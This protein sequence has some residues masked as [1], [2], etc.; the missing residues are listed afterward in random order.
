MANPMERNPFIDQG[1]GGNNPLLGELPIN[2]EEIEIE[3][4]VGEDELLEY[5]MGTEEQPYNHW[6]NLALS[7]DEDE[8]LEIANN[9]IEE[10][11]ADKESR[12]EWESTFERGFDLLGLKL[13]ETSEPFEGACTAVHPLII[14]SAV[15]FQAKASQELF[16]AKGP[17]RTQIL[18]AS[19]PEKEKQANRVMNFMNYQ[20][21]QQMPEYFDETERMLFNLPVFGSAFKKTYYDLT[22]ER[23]VVE[24]VPIDNF[25]VS[26]NASDLKNADHYTQVIYR[27]PND[28]KKDIMAGMYALPEDD[29]LME[30][31][32][33]TP[34]TLRQKMDSI[35]GIQ[36]DYSQ[37][38]QH[39]LL[40]HHCYLKIEH[41]GEEGCPCPM[42]GE[43]E[44]DNCLCVGLPYVITVDQDSKSVL[45]IRRNWN[46]NDPL[47]EKLLWFTHYRFVP[48]FG[49]YGLGY[50]H[51]LGNLTATSTA[52]MRNLI[53]AGQFATL[54]GGFKARG[55]RVTGGDEPIAPGEFREVEATGVDLN[56]AIINLPYKEP[57]ATL[58]QM[59][60]FVTTA[61]QKFADETDQVVSDASNYGPVGTTVAL[62]EQSMKFF[63]GI[64]KRLHYSQRQELQILSR[65][66]YDFLP[67]EYPYDIPLVDGNIFKQD[68]DGRIDIIPVSDPNIPSQSHRLAKAQM[69]LQ[70]SSQ[71]PPGIYNF[72]A[73]NAAILDS[74]NIDHPERFIVPEQEP[75]PL[76]P[77]SDIMQATK[78]MPIKAFPGQDHKAHIVVKQSFIQD[79]TLG[80]TPIMAKVVPI[81]EANIREHTIMMYQEQMGGM[82]EM[83][84][85][86]AGSDSSN[87]QAISTITQGAA[88]EILQNN[89]RMAE[90]GTT[91]SLEKQTLELQKQQLELETTK[92]RIDAAET[93]AGVALD[94]QKIKLEYEELEVDK[95]KLQVEASEKLAKIQ[96][97]DKHKTLDREDHFLIE[98]LKILVKES[99]VSSERLIQE[100]KLTPEEASRFAGG[101]FAELVGEQSPLAP[102]A[103]EAGRTPIDPIEESLVE[104]L[105]PLPETGRT[106]IEESLVEGLPPLPTE[107][108]PPLSQTQLDEIYYNENVLN[109]EAPLLPE[110]IDDAVP[111]LENFGEIKGKTESKAS[112]DINTEEIDD[113]VP[114]LENFSEIIGL[115]EGEKD[116]IDTESKAS[117]D[118]NTYAFGTVYDLKHSDKEVRNTSK[119]NNLVSN[120]LFGKDIDELNQDQKLTL[121][122][123]IA[124]THH[125]TL[126][127]NKTIGEAYNKLPPHLQLLVLDAKWNTGVTYKNLIKALTSYAKNKTPKN[128]ASVVK[129]SRRLSGGKPHK[130][131][132]N[133]AATLLEHVG[134]I[135]TVEEAKAY[136]LTKTD[137]IRK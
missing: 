119:A 67:D 15:K 102:E 103:L 85:Q 18:G 27:T 20:L 87:Q 12:S 35:L 36:P 123:G 56:K 50:I 107:E 1:G 23:P 104:G 4:P 19:T 55:V 39:T 72:K 59:L 32:E 53:D 17:V 58:M 84:M 8:L 38:P 30:P 31:S 7:L 62:I 136:G 14:E 112:D 105:P 117:D 64:H 115:L 28:L 111:V 113:A 6:D 29:N 96:K 46:E 129:Q 88:Q 34:S 26:Y 65:I 48:G 24:F 3:L 47:K 22:L 126:L 92:T 131:L 70:L 120:N 114:V 133:R 71:A 125:Q 83:G 86:Q 82:V 69:I 101:G 52:A 95:K 13:Q 79:P 37:N 91:E 21:T 89:Q 118:I 57:S 44:I 130:G 109:E 93:A 42:C 81:L 49:F 60:Q 77:V 68:F 61:G 75:K 110:E 80:Q 116:H 121:A 97:D 127:K 100:A 108:K 78:G 11:D 40:E 74:L 66:N 51:F 41:R 54:P 137:A 63:S 16:P 43:K 128:T 2:E 98:V 73:V 25:Y 10:F 45:S 132:D 33:V 99:G 122:K 94:K 135:E 76:D 5:I 9:V 124:N 106:P 90:M 134:I